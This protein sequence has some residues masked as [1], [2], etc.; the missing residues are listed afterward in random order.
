M[1]AEARQAGHVTRPPLQHSGSKRKPYGKVTRGGR[2]AGEGKN[3]QQIS[4][5]GLQGRRLDG[6]RPRSAQEQTWRRYRGR[7][8]ALVRS[9]RQP[10]EGAQ[11]AE[12]RGEKGD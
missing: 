8:P 5:E 11:G 7:I 1:S 4:R 3:H 12:G 6:P 9:H 2:I 10:E